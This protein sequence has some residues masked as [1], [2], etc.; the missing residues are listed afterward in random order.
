MCNGLHGKLS[1]NG[2]GI[3]SLVTMLSSI[4]ALLFAVGRLG[5]SGGGGGTAVG[6][7]G[8]Q[9]SYWCWI[10]VVAP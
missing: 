7:V 9:E 5:G 6:W 1:L 8:Q 3:P 10:L 2:G 4:V